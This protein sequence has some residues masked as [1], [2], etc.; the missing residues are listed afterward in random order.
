MAFGGITFPKIN[1]PHLDLKE[2]TN[3]DIKDVVNN[4]NSKL[5]DVGGDI[6][7]AIPTKEF[8]DVFSDFCISG[9]E[10]FSGVGDKVSGMVKETGIDKKLGD[11][12]NVKKKMSGLGLSVSDL[13]TNKEEVLPF[14]KKLKLPGVTDSLNSVPD[15][16]SMLSNSN[17]SAKVP[18]LNL[19][20]SDMTKQLGINNIDVGDSGFNLDSI[21]LDDI[22]L[23]NT[24]SVTDIVKKK[25]GGVSAKSP[26]LNDIK[27]LNLDSQGSSGTNS[28]STD[29]IL[30]M[31]SDVGMDTSKINI[32]NPPSSIDDV[33]KYDRGNTDF[34][35][36]ETIFGTKFDVK[37]AETAMESGNLDGMIPATIMGELDEHGVPLTLRDTLPI[38]MN[39]LNKTSNPK[40]YKGP[41]DVPASAIMGNTDP[42]E[43]MENPGAFMKDMLTRAMENA[44]PE[45]SYI[46]YLVDEY[47]PKLKNLKISSNKADQEM[48]REFDSD[49][50]SSSFDHKAMLNSES[51]DIITKSGIDS[52][53]TRELFSRDNNFKRTNTALGDVTAEEMFKN[54]NIQQKGL[55]FLNQFDNNTKYTQAKVG[56][57]NFYDATK[58]LRFN[59]PE[60]GWEYG[61]H[62]SL[63]L[64]IHGGLDEFEDTQITNLS[65]R[66]TIQNFKPATSHD[67]AGK[68]KEGVSGFFT[69][70]AHDSIEGRDKSKDALYGGITL[71]L[72][73]GGLYM[74]NKKYDI[75]SKIIN[76][77]KSAKTL[78]NM[79]FGEGVVTDSVYD[80][81]TGELLKH[82]KWVNGKSESVY[83]P[84]Y[85]KKIAD[86]Y[87]SSKSAK[88]IVKT[89]TDIVSKSGGSSVSKVV[90]GAMK[91]EGFTSLIKEGDSSKASNITSGF[92]SI[93]KE[94]DTTSK[95]SGKYFDWTD[96]IKGLKK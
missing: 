5:K 49:M 60:I 17:T 87:A 50:L 29:D 59:N 54:K 6:K 57:F 67:I 95:T 66:I 45:S 28:M 53:H 9:T 43:F 75:F 7:G 55:N 34:S 92:S 41:T 81:E 91:S 71:A 61:K 27:A 14:L 4:N 26:K 63:S 19:N 38:D 33:K 96:Y 22:D 2:A 83:S 44:K 40:P 85:L 48:F 74:L 69:G 32:S 16:D 21:N 18:D 47:L 68:V 58:N 64:F 30:K 42:T 88:D 70:F 86:E 13:P 82:T 65:E 1:W 35:S 72:T 78:L 94:S 37:Q 73:G 90:S 31:Y 51:T 89:G 12:L 56:N 52:N 25:S 77:G 36:I 20:G 93:I 8:G 15:L 10:G 11:G 3:F 23:N 24:G 84:K 79:K 62:K 76:G 39:E 46:S 80:T